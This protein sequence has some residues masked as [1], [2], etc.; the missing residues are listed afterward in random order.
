MKKRKFPY[1]A[2]AAAAGLTAFMQI[3][4]AFP[5]LAEEQR[6]G[7]DSE[8]AVTTTEGTEKEY[9]EATLAKLQ[10][11]VLEYDELADRIHLYNTDIQKTWQD[12]TDNK[13]DAAVIQQEL[14]S[15][16]R[17]MEKEKDLAEDENDTEQYAYYAA[18]EEALRAAKNRYIDIVEDYDKPKASK[19]IRVQE[20][21]LLSAAQTTMITY[22]TLKL[23]RDVQAKQTELYETEYA[24]AQAQVAAGTA[25][26]TEAD[27]A[28]TN[29]LSAQSSLLSMD[30][31]L[32]TLKS[33]LCLTVGWPADADPEIQ[34]VSGPE[35]DRI[36]AMNLGT[37]TEKAIGNNR[38]LISQ[39]SESFSK[40]T[41]EINN[42]LAVV[43]Q[44]E[45]Q[46]KI[47]MEELYHAVE[48]KQTAADAAR[49][50]YES[51]VIKKNSA[52]VNYQSG[53]ISKAEYQEEEL[54][55]LTKKATAETAEMELLQ[56][57]NDYEWAVQG[58]TSVE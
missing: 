49:A 18:Q 37:D 30:A 41:T 51:A 19:S 16:K 1:A 26:Q 46:L 32:K 24:I 50:G 56:A 3:A 5:A 40:N 38:T 6:L 8:E 48:E 7:P 11:N 29:L 53:W 33:S 15:Q 42:H 47:K 54:S 10:D 17:R 22:N 28:Y 36:T 39:R 43:E 13:L 23:Q 55:F 58:F 4:A 45:Q 2:Y 52:D 35:A 57:V 34:M 44:G 12:L 9:D 21:Q 20:R 31:S 25:A 27:A 14:E